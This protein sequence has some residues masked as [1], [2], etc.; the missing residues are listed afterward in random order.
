LSFSYTCALLT[1]A[2][3]NNSLDNEKLPLYKMFS[4]VYTTKRY[5]K[6]TAAA[7]AAAQK[8]AASNTAEPAS[9]DADAA[10][11]AQDD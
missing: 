9:G 4:P 7:V 3:P 6:K 11:E 10:P 2:T 5:K 8:T 1:P